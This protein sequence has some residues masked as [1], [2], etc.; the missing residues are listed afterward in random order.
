[1]PTN[2]IA[3][4]DADIAILIDGLWQFVHERFAFQAKQLKKLTGQTT[5]QCYDI[6]ACG[7]GYSGWRGMKQVIDA[8]HCFDRW[9]DL[10]GGPKE[11][12]KERLRA[13][14]I[15]KALS[16]QDD[17]FAYDD[18]GRPNGRVLESILSKLPPGAPL[19]DAMSNS[20]ADCYL[21][22][23]A[24]QEGLREMLFYQSLWLGS[25]PLYSEQSFN[26]MNDFYVRLID[27]WDGDEDLAELATM[28]AFGNNHDFDGYWHHPHDKAAL[29][30][31]DRQVKNVMAGKSTRMDPD[32]RDGYLAAM[33][34][35]TLPIREWRRLLRNVHPRALDGRLDQGPI[36]ILALSNAPED[37]WA[38]L[39]LSRHTEP[40]DAQ[41][42]TNC[43]G[44]WTLYAP[45]WDS[46]V[47][48]A[49][50]S[51][52]I[53]RFGKF[54]EG[55]AKKYDLPHLSGFYEIGFW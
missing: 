25:H 19:P 47:R 54:D 24:Q 33:A 5:A 12:S 52:A 36:T 39:Y 48:C 27:L 30:N 38:T 14:A 11:M 42:P 13:M 15:H 45:T 34:S 1:M 4:P 55:Q 46:A 16:E 3:P 41:W 51:V 7:H 44:V 6:V 28:A 17:D 32:L 22:G 49:A 23:I 31:L 2:T 37:C 43:F 50:T 10:P 8:I 9:F 29:R 53:P 40:E 18:E 20:E 21:D 35:K 26:F